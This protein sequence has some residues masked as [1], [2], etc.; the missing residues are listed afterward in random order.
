MLLIL[1]SIAI[2][3]ALYDDAPAILL[4]PC[5]VL[6][7]PRSGKLRFSIENPSQRASSDPQNLLCIIPDARK[8]PEH[9]RSGDLILK[10]LRIRFIP[11][12]CFQIQ[13][14]EFI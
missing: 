10:P 1:I 8:S 13:T 12:F 2:A 4:D 5:K 11:Q 9:P 6:I 14:L 3:S 7:I